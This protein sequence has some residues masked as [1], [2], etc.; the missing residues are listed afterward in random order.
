MRPHLT[1]CRNVLF[2]RSRRR[3]PGR[4]LA[5]AVR[6][7]LAVLVLCLTAGAAP[8][9]DETIDLTVRVYAAPAMRPVLEALASQE[10]GE[11]VDL[12][13]IEATYGSAG[14]LARQ[15]ADGA[16]VDLLIVDNPRW[17][18]FLRPRNRLLD[19]TRTVIAGDRLALIAGPTPL[20]TYP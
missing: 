9:A 3:R 5:T 11:D 18:N 6:S 12:P 16:A 20:S 19:L 14:M 15:V 7:A 13:A 17:I 10:T 4:R 1:A 2:K 8:A